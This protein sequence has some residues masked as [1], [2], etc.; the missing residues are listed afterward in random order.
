[1]DGINAREREH[2][3]KETNNKKKQEFYVLNKCVTYFT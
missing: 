1:M 2:T 3:Q